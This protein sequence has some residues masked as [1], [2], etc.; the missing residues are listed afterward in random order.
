MLALSEAGPG[1]GAWPNALQERKSV[2]ANGTAS[3]RPRL[4]IVIPLDHSY[5]TAAAIQPGPIEFDALRLDQAR[6]E[7]EQE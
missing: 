6:D 7:T 3:D 2:K 4:L 5:L 1:G